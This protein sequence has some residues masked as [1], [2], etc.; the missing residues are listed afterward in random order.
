[1]STHFCTWHHLQVLTHHDADGGD[2]IYYD[3][4]SVD[5][6]VQNLTCNGGTYRAITSAMGFPEKPA[7]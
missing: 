4:I 7:R 1:V 2:N 6:D 5:G 3:E